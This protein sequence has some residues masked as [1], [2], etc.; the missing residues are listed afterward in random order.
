MSSK[1]ITFSEACNLLRD[2]SAISL[3]GLNY[4]LRPFDERHDTIVLSLVT[5]ENPMRVHFTRQENPEIRVSGSSLYLQEEGGEEAQLSLHQLLDVEFPGSTMFRTVETAVAIM[6]AMHQ[7][8][9]RQSEGSDSAWDELYEVAKLNGGFPTIWCWVTEMA[10]GARG[11]REERW[12]TGEDPDFIDSARVAA[13]VMHNYLTDPRTHHEGKNNLTPG[14]V[15][16]LWVEVD[17][18]M[19]EAGRTRSKASKDAEIQNMIRE[20]DHVASRG[21]YKHGVF[22]PSVRDGRQVFTWTLQGGPHILIEQGADG[23]WKV[24]SNPE[25]LGSPRPSIA[26]QLFYDKLPKFP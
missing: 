9:C 14:K 12:A 24:G 3:S 18:V 19:G 1:A 25:T 20:L 10:M 21:G 8:V 7:E 13:Q 16:G 2:A 17:R 6:D 5:D 22:V 23:L 26:F 15:A 4:V 11:A